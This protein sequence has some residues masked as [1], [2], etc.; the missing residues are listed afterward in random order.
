MRQ[1]VANPD[2]LAVGAQVAAEVGRDRVVQVERALFA[3]LHHRQRG[4]QLGDAAD[5]DQGVRAGWG[6]A[7]QVGEAEPAAVDHLAV[8][9]QDHNQA[10]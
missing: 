2:R 8:L 7:G 9:D 5:A 10:G 4:E 1:Q 6:A 3:Q